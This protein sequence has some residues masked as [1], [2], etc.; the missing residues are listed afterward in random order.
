MLNLTALPQR[1]VEALGRD[2][3]AE[4]V[5]EKMP[6]VAL[7]ISKNY[8]FPLRAVEA[9]LAF[10]PTPL[11]EIKPL[12]ETPE[13]GKKLM[14]LMPCTGSP[15]MKSMETILRLYN[16]AEMVFRTVAF[17]NL[18]VARNTLAA[19]WLASDSP[20]SFWMD[21]DMICPAGD[22]AWY[23]AATDNPKMSDVYAGLH[24]IYR[25]LVHQKPF[26]SVAYIGRRRGAPP[27]F[28]GGDSVAMRGDL[29]RGPRNELKEVAWC[30]FGGVLLHRK[31]LEGIIAKEGPSIEVKSP[32]LRER[33]HYRYAFFHPKDVDTPGDDLPFAERAGRAGYYPVIDLSVWA[34]HVGTKAYSYT[35]L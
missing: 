21:A 29:R 3:V 12:Y 16:P 18:S 22:A 35:D 11:H 23:K 15:S 30:G 10:D 31:V 8:A 27:Q 7:W 4:I 9:L 13:P 19:I 25:M 6:T 26:V 17:N 32:Q 1:Y 14:I 20:W 2:K 34:A 24:T 33:F 28:A 5:G